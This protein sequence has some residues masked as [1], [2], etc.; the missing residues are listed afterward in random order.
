MFSKKTKKTWGTIEKLAEGKDWRIDKIVVKP[1][2]GDHLH[3]QPS[4]KHT[5]YVA[6]GMGKVTVGQRKSHLVEAHIKKG[7]EF[8]VNGDWL[9]R[10]QNEGK[11]ELVII[12][13]SYGKF[14]LSELVYNKG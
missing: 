8:I 3:C 4:I 14:D 5:C 1:G 10:F 13:S 11:K 12:Q 9:H 7:D 2:M 6:E